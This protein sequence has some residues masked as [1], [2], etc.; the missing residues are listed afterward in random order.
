MSEYKMSE[1]YAY[2]SLA[3][4]E[5]VPLLQAYRTA[6]P[7]ARE[8]ALAMLRGEME[9]PQCATSFDDCPYPDHPKGIDFCSEWTP[10]DK[11]D[12]Q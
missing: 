6:T 7:E 9:C 5:E 12:D 2:A 4:S 10:R 1:H 8:R 11:G 3:I